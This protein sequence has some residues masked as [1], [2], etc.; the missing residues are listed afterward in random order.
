MSNVSM[1]CHR[2]NTFSLLKA[3]VEND[4]LVIILVKFAGIANNL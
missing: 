1:I 4:L 2:R 3:F